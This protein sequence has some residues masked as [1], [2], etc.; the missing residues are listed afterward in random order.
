MNFSLSF[1]A[2]QMSKSRASMLERTPLWSAV[3]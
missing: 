3:A 2:S 1:V